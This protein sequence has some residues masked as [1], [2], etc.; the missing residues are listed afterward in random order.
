MSPKAPF[1]LNLRKDWSCKL[2]VFCFPIFSNKLLPLFRR[3]NRSSFRFSFERRQGKR[4]KE[5]KRCWK[6]NANMTFCNIL[7]QP[8]SNLM[9]ANN[10]TQTHNCYY[11]GRALEPKLKR[12]LIYMQSK[13][14]VRERWAGLQK[15]KERW[16]KTCFKVFFGRTQV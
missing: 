4:K 8:T 3:G 2:V 16:R 5:R 7:L 15:R 1:Y 6:S 11:T 14:Q 9:L 12:K 13:F 10:I